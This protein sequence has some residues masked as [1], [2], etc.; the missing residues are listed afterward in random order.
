MKGDEGGNFSKAPNRKSLFLLKAKIKQEA[1]SRNKEYNAA[2]NTF[3]RIS[4]PISE[5]K[6]I[7]ID[8]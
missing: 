4:G 3:I 2:F 1:A 5:V 6:K 8:E 7:C